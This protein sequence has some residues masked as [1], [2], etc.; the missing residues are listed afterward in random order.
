MTNR[1]AFDLL[2][3]ARVIHKIP[4]CDPSGLPLG[5]TATPKK[6][7]ASI[8]DIGLLQRLCRV[9]VELELQ[10]EN[11]LAIYRGKMAEQFVA[12]E[13]LAWHSSELFYWAR[14]ARGSSAE[15]DFLA[16]KK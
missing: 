3:K 2:V 15:V 1:K 4:S 9:P 10:Q 13:L 6:F 7:K 12:Q 5:A 11:L 16:V 14:D 8:L